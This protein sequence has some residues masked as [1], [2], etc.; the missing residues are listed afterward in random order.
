MI[1][2]PEERGETN[3]ALPSVKPHQA[4]AGIQCYSAKYVIRYRPV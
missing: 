4:D 1:M 2:D 3:L